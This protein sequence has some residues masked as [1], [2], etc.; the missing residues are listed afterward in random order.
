MP[1]YLL[2]FIEGEHKHK[3]LQKRRLPLQIEEGEG[4]RDHAIENLPQRPASPTSSTAT[5]SSKQEVSQVQNSAVTTSQETPLTSVSH[6]PAI[7]F[8][9]ATNKTPETLQDVRGGNDKYDKRAVEKS[10]KRS[11]FQKFLRKKPKPEQGS[12]VQLSSAASN[13]VPRSEVSAAAAATTILNTPNVDTIARASDKEEEWLQKDS[14]LLERVQWARRDREAL[15]GYIEELRKYITDLEHLLRLKSSSGILLLSETLKSKAA[16]LQ[17]VGRKTQKALQRLHASLRMMNKRKGPWIFS[18]QLAEDFEMA[19]RDFVNLNDYLPLR[20]A[21]LHFTLQRHSSQSAEESELFVAE[22]LVSPP[23]S[24][25][26]LPSR[27]LATDLNQA[28]EYDGLPE[29]DPFAKW[30]VV[31]VES[32]CGD[33]HWLFKD[34]ENKW[35]SCETLADVL[36]RPETGQKM[37]ANQRIKLALLI[38]LSYL[39]L[40]SVRPSCDAISLNSFKY[41]IRKGEESSWDDGD[42]LI[43]YPYISFGFGQRPVDVVV[44]GRQKAPRDHNTVIYELGIKLVQIG[45][46]KAYGD[47]KAFVLST[48]RSWA[49]TNLHEL[50]SYVTL[51]YAEIARDCLQYSAS[52]IPAQDAD[53]ENVFLADIATRLGELKQ[54]LIGTLAGDVVPTPRPHDGGQ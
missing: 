9:H 28:Q 13:G 3:K 53:K 22:T 29:A 41:Y 49:L 14:D 7:S 32:L 54:R 43:L 31:R 4:S 50:E 1:L 38:T 2:P 12:S 27:L 10:K 48:A 15:F 34:S 52:S 46:C 5:S 42:P 8:G 20:E 6:L 21:S 23:A 36:L 25:T 18:L 19:G 45:C 24:N 33:L 51:P 16:S 40:V 11:L 17:A 44:G 39:Y 37:T 26:V 47:A 35:Q 30:G